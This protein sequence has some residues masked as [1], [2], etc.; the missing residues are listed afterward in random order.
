M[1]VPISKTRKLVQYTNHMT[2]SHYNRNLVMSVPIRKKCSNEEEEEKEDV[3][4]LEVPY[5]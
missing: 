3:K 2:L 5:L 4:V 1:V